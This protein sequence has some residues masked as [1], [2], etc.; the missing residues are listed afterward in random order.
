MFSVTL[1]QLG[2]MIFISSGSDVS[3]FDSTA[4]CF[5]SDLLPQHTRIFDFLF[6]ILSGIEPAV[7]ISIFV[8]VVS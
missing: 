7:S 2:A 3:F 8:V 5:S 6:W 4:F 1:T